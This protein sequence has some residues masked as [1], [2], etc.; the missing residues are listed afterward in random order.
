M[1]M[2]PSNDKLDISIFETNKQTKNLLRAIISVAKFAFSLLSQLKY[3][4][5]AGFWPRFASLY[6][7]VHAC[8]RFRSDSGTFAARNIRGLGLCLGIYLG[9]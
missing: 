5:F 6:N 4:F 2:P 9:L 8:V 1:P 7:S 3:I